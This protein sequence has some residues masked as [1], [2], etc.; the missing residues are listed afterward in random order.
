MVVIAWP[1][2]RVT[3]AYKSLKHAN[4]TLSEKGA[5]YVQEFLKIRLILVVSASSKGS[6]GKDMEDRK[7]IKACGKIVETQGQTAPKASCQG[8]KWCPWRRRER[9]AHMAPPRCRCRKI[10]AEHNGKGTPMRNTLGTSMSMIDYCRLIDYCR[11]QCSCVS[12]YIYNTCV[13]SCVMHHLF[14]LMLSNALSFCHCSK[15]VVTKSE[16]CTQ[17]PESAVPFDDYLLEKTQPSCPCKR[18]DMQ[19]LV[20]LYTT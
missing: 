2:N 12:I 9:S 6:T 19:H 17:R 10:E 1:W 3:I 8:G 13:I 5:A 15:G 20:K 4:S 18:K 11:I 16:W 7:G 14:A